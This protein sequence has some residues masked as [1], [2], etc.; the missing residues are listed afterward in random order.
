MIESAKQR[1]PDLKVNRT[2]TSR[3][4]TLYGIIGEYCFAQWLFG[5][6]ISHSQVDTKGKIDFVQGIEVKTSA[7]PFSEKLNLLVREDYVH[8]RKP[9]FYVQTIIDL[10]NRHEHNLE[11]DFNC[12]L[13]GYAT[14]EDVENAPLR[15]FGSKF[16]GYGGYKCRFISIANL[17]SVVELR[18][19]IDC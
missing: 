8:K 5:D 6:W 14:G 10:P 16:G 2:R 3:F 15:D 7:F 18:N 13:A 1:A 11:P 9:R 19:L 12:I 4:D 17:K